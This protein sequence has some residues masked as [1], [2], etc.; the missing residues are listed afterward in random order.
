[1]GLQLMKFVYFCTRNSEMESAIKRTCSLMDRASGYGPEG[2]GFES[3]QVHRDESMK[4]GSF[5]Y[6]FI[7]AMRSEW[8]RKIPTGFAIGISFQGYIK[9]ADWLFF[10]FD[11]ALIFKRKLFFYHTESLMGLLCVPFFRF[12]TEIFC[13]IVNSSSIQTLLRCVNAVSAHCLT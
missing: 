4:I 8:R 6:V 13:F 11:G 3:L 2:W 12:L 1:M 5:F 7:G 9:P 10:R